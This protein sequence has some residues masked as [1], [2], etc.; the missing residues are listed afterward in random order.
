MSE[1]IRESSRQGAN[2]GVEVVYSAYTDWRN[3]LERD[4]AKDGCSTTSQRKLLLAD[5]HG[6]LKGRSAGWGVEAL[7]VSA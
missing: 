4:P 7:G 6:D 2:V 1:R 5:L 3:I